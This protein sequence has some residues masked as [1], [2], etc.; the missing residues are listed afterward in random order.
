MLLLEFLL[1]FLTAFSEQCS[2]IKKLVLQLLLSNLK[3]HICSAF[4][5]SD[6]IQY[7]PSHT[8]FI[9]ILCTHGQQSTLVHGPTCY[10]LQAAEISWAYS[11]VLK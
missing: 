2:R 7:V 6:Q 3:K 9:H 1:S 10:Q 11:G 8:I 5:K 4:L